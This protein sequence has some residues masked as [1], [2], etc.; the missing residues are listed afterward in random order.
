MIIIKTKSINNMN[1]EF[2]T[3]NLIVNIEIDI[4]VSKFSP[5]LIMNEYN[6]IKRELN[7]LK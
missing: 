5:I 3:N 2:F 7:F 6:Y 4:I 1:N